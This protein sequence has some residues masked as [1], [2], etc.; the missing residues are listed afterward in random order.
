M[1]TDRKAETAELVQRAY[2]LLLRALA[3]E[4]VGSPDK[5]EV[6]EALKRVSE[7]QAELLFHMAC[8]GCK[9]SFL[10]QGCDPATDEV[11]TLASFNVTAADDATQVH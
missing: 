5:R 2:V 4:H 11:T 10:A 8:D 6:G 3:R 1:S 7:G 9:L